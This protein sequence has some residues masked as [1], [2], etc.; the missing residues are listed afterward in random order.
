MPEPGVN[1][2]WS[3]INNRNADKRLMNG[4]IGLG[5][6]VGIGIL[7]VVIVAAVAV[8]LLTRGGGKKS[9]TDSGT[10]TPPANQS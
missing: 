9:G 1:G 8:L 4:F 3:G 6:R 5:H 2:S 10:G 7:V